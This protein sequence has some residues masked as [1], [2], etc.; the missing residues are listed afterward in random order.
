MKGKYEMS[1][2]PNA[3]YRKVCVRRKKAVKIP[4]FVWE[5]T[6]GYGR[7]KRRMIYEVD[8]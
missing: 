2:R 1:T 7:R 6:E 4:V 3:L 8:E 5:D